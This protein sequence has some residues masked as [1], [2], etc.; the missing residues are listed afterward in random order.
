MTKKMPINSAYVFS[1]STHLNNRCSFSPNEKRRVRIIVRTMWIF[2]VQCS[3]SNVEE[4]LN[5]LE[6]REN[7]WKLLNWRVLTR[8]ELTHLEM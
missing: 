6:I 1:F 4:D 7:Y 5:R 8:K 3:L 2:N